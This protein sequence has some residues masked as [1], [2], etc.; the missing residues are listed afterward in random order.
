MAEEIVIGHAWQQHRRRYAGTS[1]RVRYRRP[2]SGRQLVA[3]N[4]PK[5]DDPGGH[6]QRP[7]R[8]IGLAPRDREGARAGLDCLGA[9]DA[10]KRL[11]A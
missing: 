10:M 1:Y 9:P 3:T 5:A 6:H 11:I 2:N 8:E 7:F 4:L